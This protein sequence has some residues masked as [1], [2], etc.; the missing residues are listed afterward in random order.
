MFDIIAQRRRRPKEDQPLSIQGFSKGLNTTNPQLA[1]EKE[2]LANA[3]NYY[4]DKRGNLIPRPGITQFTTTQLDGNAVSSEQFRIGGDLFTIVCTSTFKIYKVS[5]AGV[6]TLIGTTTGLAEVFLYG[7]W[8]CVC[9]T[10][11]LKYVDSDGIL[12]MAYDAGEDNALHDK[13]DD[14]STGTIKIHSGR[15]QAGVKFLFPTFADSFKIP[16]VE[17]KATLK[18]VGSPTGTVVGKLYDVTSGTLFATSSNSYDP[19][20]LLTTE[21]D[22]SFLFTVDTSDKTGWMDS[23]KQYRAVVEYTGGDSSNCVELS[24]VTDVD[25]DGTN[26]TTVW[27]DGLASAR[28][29]LAPNL[30]PKAGYGLT[31]LKRPFLGNDPDNPG[32]IWYGNVTIFDW[33]TPNGGG[34]IGIIDD[35][36][37]SSPIGGMGSLYGELYIFGTNEVPYL[38]K[39]SGTQPEDYALLDSF[40]AVAAEHRTIVNRPNDIWYSR[41]GGTNNLLGTDRYGSTSTFSHAAS[42]IDKFDKN[43][44]TGQDNHAGFVEALGLYFLYIASTDTV[45]VS[46]TILPYQKSNI[47]GDISYPWTEFKFQGLPTM[48]TQHQTDFIM[49]LDDGHLYKFDYQALDDDDVEIEYNW[50]TAFVSLPFYNVDLNLVHMIGTSEG[51]MVFD[52]N[53]YTE[54]NNLNIIRTIE[55][56]LGQIGLLVTNAIMLVQAADFLVGLGETLPVIFDLNIRC[57]TVQL[58]GVG[59][60]RVYYEPA[61]ISGCLLKYKTLEN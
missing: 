42:I 10:S 58:E 50:R 47:E 55:I 44:S 35:S 23:N 30:P 28:M 54:T 6:P 21:L 25:L 27:V 14:V 13:I 39:L 43:W 1:L 22:Y 20:T 7:D 8:C 15:V 31:T 40:K 9:D 37:T 34:W 61:I 57:S 32:W 51:G 18:K 3:L 33:S 24:T 26:F 12:S 45:L 49:G 41:E 36:R 38:S 4:L 56:N 19:S 48:M 5:S 11:Y 16:F 60:I 59:L 29:W 17:F 2:E 46:H 53:I 52:L